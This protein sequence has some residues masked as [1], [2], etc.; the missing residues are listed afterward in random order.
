[1]PDHIN[2]RDFLALGATA[3]AVGGVAPFLGSGPA[4]ALAGASVTAGEGLAA[5]ANR[6]G[7]L[8]GTAVS[9]ADLTDKR[10]QE[11]LRRDCNVLTPEN[12][13]KWGVV[14]A[15]PGGPLN[16]SAAEKIYDFARMNGMAM[17]GHAL[18][19]WS[20]QPKW[21]ADYIGA[22]SAR[23]AG[24]YLQKYAYDVAKHWKG[25]V[26]QWDVV[27]EPIGARDVILDRLYGPK[28]GDQ[29][30][31]LVFEAAAEADPGALRVLNHDLIAQKFWYQESQ[32]DSTV[33][34]IDR[35]MNRGAKIQCFGF[36]AHLMTAYGFSEGKWQRFCDDLTGMGLKLMITE[37]DVDD[38]GT[39]GDVQHRDAQSSALAGALLDVMLSNPECQG[40]VTWGLTDKYSWLRKVP[41]RQRS[42]GQPQRPTLYDDKYQKKLLWQTMAQAIDKAE[43]RGPYKGRPS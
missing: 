24:D 1:M 25:R 5:R 16:F 15:T 7:L 26:I 3:A 18:S 36:E 4:E 29:Y 28:L 41:E 19:W 10:L 34:L 33:R 35:M 13:L 31:D 27:N 42:D 32:L 14:Q 40:M 23:E 9:G 37:L 20:T 38:A 22:M 39:I 43:P 30:M 17:R 12:E 11:I 2:R 6:K 8:C 21:A